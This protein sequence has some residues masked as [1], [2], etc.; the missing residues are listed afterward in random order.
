MYKTTFYGKMADL[1]SNFAWLP[2]LEERN[3]LWVITRPGHSVVRKCYKN[4]TDSMY[5]NWG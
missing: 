1:L 5:K 2:N 3:E 4:S